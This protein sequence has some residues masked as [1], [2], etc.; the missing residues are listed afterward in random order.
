MT[1]G[2]PDAVSGSCRCGRSHCR[3]VSL[4]S[5]QYFDYCFSRCCFAVEAVEHAPYKSKSWSGVGGRAHRLPPKLWLSL[6]RMPPCLPPSFPFLPCLL[7]RTCC[8]RYYCLPIK[9]LSSFLPDFLASLLPTFIPSFLPS[10]RPF[11]LPQLSLYS[12]NDHPNLRRHWT[13][14]KSSQ[15]SKH[16]KNCA[17]FVALLQWTSNWFQ[18]SRNN[19]IAK[20]YQNALLAATSLTCS[21]VAKDFKIMMHGHWLICNLFLLRDVTCAA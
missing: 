16:G 18:R 17:G 19:Y 20:Q 14:K 21:N 6:R 15:K 10:M 2:T 3:A 4:C 9:H 13:I 12:W 5:T 11:C 7:P 1:A 8:F